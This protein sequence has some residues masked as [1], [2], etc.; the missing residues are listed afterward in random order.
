MRRRAITWAA[1]LYPARWRQRYGTEF[2]ALLEESGGGWDAMADVIRG[3][4]AM[5]MRS[6]SIWKFVAACGVIGAA[7]AGLV[8]WRT[9]K[10]YESIAVLRMDGDD[11][12]AR[13]RLGKILQEVLSRNALS[14]I[15]TTYGLYTA[16]RAQRPIEDVIRDMRAHI[17]ASL[18]TG[19][20]PAAFKIS[21]IGSSPA[22][23]NRV[24][25]LL[26]SQ[27]IDKNLKAGVAAGHG[28][29]GAGVMEVLDPPNLPQQPRSPNLSKLI[30][31]G[32][33][34]GVLLGL[35]A[36]GMAVWSRRDAS[37]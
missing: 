2:G 33:L 24:T 1:R 26:V 21:F 27:L 15:I 17:N 25:G 30:G 31:I 5:R 13:E 16:D 35:V 12:V 6:G 11:S 32:V 4:L 3:A 20:H 7:I 37:A 34:L 19:I 29:L 22:Q 23:A 8:S 9:P 36:F 10:V 18:V 14:T 28:A